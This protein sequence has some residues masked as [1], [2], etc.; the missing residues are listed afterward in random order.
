MALINQNNIIGITSITS[1]GS[2]NV[3]T[4]HTNDTTERLRVTT[5][6]LSFSGTNASLDTSGNLTVGGNVSV[7]G[8]LTYEDVTNIDSVGIITAQAG[9]HVT[10][11][12]LGVGAFNNSSYDTNAQNLLLASS[13]NTGMTIRSAGSTP[14]AMIH[15]ADGT[16]DNSQ[17]RAGRIMYQHDGDNLTFH[18]AN[19]ERLR[20]TGGGTILAGGQSSSYDGG[21]VNLELRKDSNTVGGSMTLVNDTASQAGATCEIDCYQNYRGSGKIVFGRENANNWQSSAGGA[22]SFLAF[23]TNNAGTVAER[24]RITSAGL[25]GVGTNNPTLTAGNGVHIAGG[26]AALKLQNTNNGDWAFIEYADESNTTKYIQGYRDSSGVYAI[27]PGTS[28]NATPGI[29]LTS[30]GNIGINRI[31]PDQKL[32]VSGCAEFNAYDSASGSGGYYTS[33]GLIIGNLY[34]AGKSY[35]GSDDRTACIWQERGLDVD[36][37]TNDAL[38]MKITYDGMMGLGTAT[39]TN[40]HGKGLHIADANAGIRIQNTANTGWAYVEYADESNTVKY[41]Q[42]YRDANGLYGIRPGNSLSASTGLTIN[43]SGIVTKPNHPSFQVSRNQSTWSI[44]GG[45]KFDWDLVVHNTGSHFSASTDRFTA[46]V[47]GTYQFNFSIIW[48]HA[49]LNNEWVSLRKN[50]NRFTGGDVHFSASF[51]SNKWDHTAYSASVYLS[52]GDYVEMFNGGNTVSY[53]GS[54]WAQWSGY[55]VG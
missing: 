43:S 10:G 5:S 6:G 52:S 14:F 17:K 41:V 18:T 53:H 23:H 46:P 12:R 3:L 28:L 49:T 8:T 34:D 30:A 35:S 39:P 29:T 45:T 54:T 33:K 22:A 37:A 20:I 51:G 4:I 44:A 16:T 19:E 47:A 48:Y 27:R 13:G 40:T 42:G 32:N 11:G 50:G 55:L 38:R 15:F 31:N 1:P 24:L 2:S 26:N 21:F 36:F 9:I 7:G 25:L